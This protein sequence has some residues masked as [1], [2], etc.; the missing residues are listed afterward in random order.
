MKVPISDVKFDG[1]IYPRVKPST[2]IV[3]EYADAMLSGDSFPPIILE[4]GTNK[5]LDGYH[6]WKAQQR[7][8]DQPS[9]D[10]QGTQFAEIE[11][12]FHVIPDGIPAKLYAYSLSKRNGHRLTAGEARAVAREVCEANPDFS[13]AVIAEHVGRSEDSV[14]DYV[15]DIKGR[16]KEQQR[17]TILRL[18]LLAGHKKKSLTQW[19]S[20]TEERLMNLYQKSENSEF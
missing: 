20:N 7:L 16:R 3:E 19:A 10:G 6:R 9:L 4:E 11:A 18:D 8:F 14:M 2:T 12:E 5:L 1:S 15:R 13:T 17:G